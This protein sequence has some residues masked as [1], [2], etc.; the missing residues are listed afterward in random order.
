MSIVFRGTRNVRKSDQTNLTFYFYLYLFYIWHKV[1]A[2][3]RSWSP[4]I[5]LSRVSS[6]S[7]GTRGD[8]Q[9][10]QVGRFHHVDNHVRSM[11]WKGK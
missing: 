5:V 4:T 6:T 8:R 3:E 11:Q 10:S 9:K 1:Q 7:T 2:H